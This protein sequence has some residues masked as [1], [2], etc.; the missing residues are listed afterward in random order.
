MALR[1]S[2]PK[3]IK[4]EGPDGRAVAGARIS[5]R[6]ISFSDGRNASGVVPES[7]AESRAVTTGPDG[8][9]TLDYLAGAHMLVA[10]RVTAASIGTQDFSLTDWPGREALGENITVQLKPTSRLVGRVRTRAGEPVAGQTVEIWSK[11]GNWPLESHTVGF[12]NGPVRTAADGSF[13]T[14]DNLLVGSQYRVVVRAPGMEPIL[15]DWITIGEQPRVLLPM[16]QRPLR[17][18]SGRAVDRQGKP[19]AGAQVFQSGDGPERTS[20]RTDAGGRFTLGGFCQGPVC[21]FACGEGFRFFGRL[22]RPGNEDVMVELTRTSERPARAMK[23]L[24]DPIPLEESRALARRLLEPRWKAFDAKNDAAKFTDLPRLVTV[25]P[26]GVLQRLDGIEFPGPRMKGALLIHAAW[27]LARSDPAEAETVAAG[28]DEPGGHVRALVAVFDALPDQDRQHKVAVLDRATLQAKTA[29]L[30]GGRVVQLAAV[31]ERWYEFGEKEKARALMNDALRLANTLAKGTPA[32]RLLA[33][34]LARFDLPSA[35]A[36]AKE[37]PAA[38]MNSEAEILVNIA[39]HLAPDNPA[40]AERILS[41]LP[42]EPGRD[43]FPPA[44]A[45]KMASADPARARRLTDQS[46]REMDRPNRYLFLALGLKSSDPAGASQAFQTA[47]QGI[48]RLIKGAEDYY[49]D[50]RGPR[51]IVLPAVEQL[52]PALVAEYFWRIVATRSSVGDPRSGNEFAPTLLALLLASYDRDVAAIVFEPVR[53][54]LEH[55]DDRELARPVVPLAF[56]AWSL[57]DPRAAA[58]RLEQLPVTPM[59]DSARRRVAE[60]LWLPHEARWRNVWL[61]NSYMADMLDR[62]FF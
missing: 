11:G 58:A 1:K 5:P 53:A 17:T 3:T 25:D 27:V 37:F 33:P 19:V 62:D 7:L 32:R 51:E 10:V 44:I 21:L 13:Q 61:N 31:A 2:A 9:A 50:G 56:E 6:V 60:L 15:S 49:S 26:V 57:F 28:I 40:E 42:P 24:A 16:I 54:W 45:L 36:I 52:D 18:I 48:D 34:S 22:I 12:D 59:L 4:I 30:P 38:G 8:K 20:V 47:M 14:P 39:F 55:A 41:V 43:R 29:N 23:M 35:L 46:Q